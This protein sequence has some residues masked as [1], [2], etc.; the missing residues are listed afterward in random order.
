M[1]TREEIIEVVRDLWEEFSYY[2]FEEE[3]KPTEHNI[4]KKLEELNGV[5]LTSEEE[6]LVYYVLRTDDEI[7]D[8]SDT[9][10]FV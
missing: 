5:E 6:S 10:Y 7:G 2:P 9:I 8:C 4:I 1:I 3:N